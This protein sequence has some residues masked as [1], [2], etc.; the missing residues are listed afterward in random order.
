MSPSY[1][2]G[3]D[4]WKDG[5][6]RIDPYWFAANPGDPAKTFYPQFWRLLRD[7]GIPFRLHWGKF[8][9]AYGQDDRSWIDFFRAQYPRWDDFLRL[10]AA[11]D[12]N[13]IF[14]TTYWRDRFGLWTEPQPS[15]A[16][17]AVTN[18]TIAS[19]P[20][21]APTDPPGD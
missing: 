12:P 19:P 11:R 8:Q 16:P 3:E 15:A 10:R 14:L 18:A 4:E 9:P 2:T 1:S 7:H 20:T 21:P 5:A 13:N 6:F 17:R